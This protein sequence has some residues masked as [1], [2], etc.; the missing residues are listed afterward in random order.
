MYLKHYNHNHDSL[1]RFS[2]SPSL[3]VSGS[4]KTQFKDSGYYRKRLPRGVR[5][6]LKKSIR[7]KERINVG[8][9]PGIDRQVQDF[10]KSKKYNKVHVYGPGKKVRYQAD[11][12]WKTHPID[13][14]EYE[15]GSKEWLE[16]KD[17]AME[18]AS[19]RGLAV[20]IPE[21]SSATRKNVE[22][23]INHNK[24]VTVYQL[25]SRSRLLDRKKR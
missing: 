17:I 8:D 9:A 5:K 12:K 19:T 13:A 14:P 24:N 18:R 4:S 25:S 2:K 21:G 11:K 20:V 23:L 16:K 10:L 6:E 1:G 7:R 22:R 15:V 3:F